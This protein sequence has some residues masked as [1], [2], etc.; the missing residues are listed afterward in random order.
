[1]HPLENS[2]KNG[3]ASIESST[4]G[5]AVMKV[6][7][8]SDIKPTT[9]LCS[10]FA[11][12]G[13]PVLHHAQA[14]PRTATSTSVT[15][16][17]LDVEDVSGQ[18]IPLNTASDVELR[19]H[20]SGPRARVQPNSPS[21]VVGNIPFKLLATIILA[22]EM[23]LTFF[24]LNGSPSI[25]RSLRAMQDGRQTDIDKFQG[26]WAEFQKRLQNVVLLAT[27]LLTAN[28]A[29]LAIQSV[30]QQGLFYVPQVYSYVSI[31]AS[32]G[33]IT[34][35]FALRTP[36]VLMGSTMFYLESIAL[37]L[38]IP[39]ALFLYSIVNF[40][41]ALTIHVASIREE[42]PSL[43]WSLIGYV[44]CWLFCA[45]LYVFI[46]EPLEKRLLSSPRGGEAQGRLPSL[47][48]LSV[49]MSC[50]G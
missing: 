44:I 36:R 3:L 19:P 10:R 35:G 32:L 7:E 27:V 8:D 48:G 14:I 34:A 4:D 37:I 5:A 18:S 26:F 47:W 46:T 29:F 38:G 21:F 42:P 1:M 39:S 41:V 49:V 50:N 25:L 22:L 33:C 15:T 2:T 23:S 13:G 30:D 45:G 20:N 31:T 9:I 43:H 11:D 40:F 16:L 6:E 28:I 12:V 24:F 17:R